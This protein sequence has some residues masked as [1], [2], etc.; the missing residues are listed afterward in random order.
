MAVRQT[1]QARVVG[2]NTDPDGKL[3]SL[4]VE[5]LSA[6]DAGNAKLTSMK[7]EV[8]SATGGGGAGGSGLNNVMIVIA[9]G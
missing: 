9:S 8:M 6:G 1:Q 5:A 4:K 3:T 2:Y 7:V